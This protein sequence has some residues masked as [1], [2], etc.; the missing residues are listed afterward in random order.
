MLPRPLAELAEIGAV[1]RTTWL[2]TLLD[3]T[4]A[5]IGE[6]VDAE[7]EPPGAG[8]ARDPLRWRRAS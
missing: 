4:E 6:L 1:V 5:Q 2:I 7:G 8:F 3:P